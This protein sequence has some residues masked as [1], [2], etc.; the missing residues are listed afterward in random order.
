MKMLKYCWETV[1][2]LLQDTP[3]LS[4]AYSFQAPSEAPQITEPGETL[5]HHQMLPLLFNNKK[6]YNISSE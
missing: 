4:S 6:L 5:E 2:R 3:V 1:Y